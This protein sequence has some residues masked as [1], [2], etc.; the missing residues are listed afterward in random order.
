MWNPCYRFGHRYTAITCCCAQWLTDVQVSGVQ[1]KFV[2]QMLNF[3][4][5]SKHLSAVRETNA[6]VKRALFLSSTDRGAAM[7]VIKKWLHQHNIVGQ[8]LRTNLHQKQYVDQV[9]AEYS[10]FLAFSESSLGTLLFALPQQ[11]FHDMIF[12]TV[13]AT[14]LH[15]TKPRMQ[16]QKVLKHLVLD[17]SLEHEHIA[18]L[19]VLTEKVSMPSGAT[20]DRGRF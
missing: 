20:T 14:T 19:W 12:H 5:F 7:A 18:L 3:S 2:Q 8:L 16:V 4:N 13:N 15:Q 17:G 9:G 6:I 11:V 1:C 10:C